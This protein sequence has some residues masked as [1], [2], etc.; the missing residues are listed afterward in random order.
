MSTL[1]ID[2]G[3]TKFT[4]AVFDEGRMVERESRA[5]DREGGR[6]WMVRQIESVTANW[7]KRFDLARDWF[8]RPGRFQSAA[9]CAIYTR[10]RLERLRSA[11]IRS[12]SDWH[13]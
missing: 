9:G 10:R 4:M 5:T 6:E 8:R 2:I 13:R 7:K 12:T 3:G 1:A 11:W